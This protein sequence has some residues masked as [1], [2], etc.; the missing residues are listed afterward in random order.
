METAGTMLYMSPTRLAHNIGSFADDIWAIGCSVVRMALGGNLQPWMREDEDPRGLG[1]PQL[2]FRAHQPPHHPAIPARLSH[3]AQAFVLRCFTR[4]PEF[5]PSASELL[6]DP[7][8][9]D[10]V[11]GVEPVDEYMKDI[12]ICDA[13]REHFTRNFQ[14]VPGGTGTNCVTYSRIGSN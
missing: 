6:N 2:L 11:E 4:D 7:W 14:Y 5:R 9:F 3:K 12:N 13:D 8:F 10:P 1:I